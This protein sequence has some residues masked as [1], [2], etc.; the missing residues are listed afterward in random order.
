MS[1]TSTKPTVVIVGAGFAGVACAKELA[2][3]DIP[4]TLARPAQLP[5]VPAAA[6][7]SR[8]CRARDHRRRAPDPSDL[9]EGPTVSMRQLEVTG[10]DPETR[11]VTTTD[12]QTFTGDYVVVAA[13]TKPN[14]FN[15]PGADRA[16]VPALLGARTRRTCGLA[17]FEL[18]EE[19][20]DNPARSSRGAQLRDRRRR[21]DRRRDRGRARR[22][23]EPGHAEAVPQPR[24]QPHPHLSRRSRPSRAPCLLGQGPR[25]RRGEAPAQRRDADARHGRQGGRKNKVV[26]TDGTEILTRT[27]RLGRRHPGLDRRRQHVGLPIGRGGCLTAEPDL[28]VDGHPS[29]VRHR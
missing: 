25:V 16:R 5:A 14:F 23:R 10:V 1:D 20:A 3:H 9:R 19:A 11:T 7:P 24:R 27:R 2:K 13:G 15:T 18:F 6:V 12:G 21:T 28:S 29:V 26:L 17:V 8:H 22:P 4:V